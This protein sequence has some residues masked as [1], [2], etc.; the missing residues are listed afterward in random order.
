MGSSVEWGTGKKNG[1]KTS[2][3][4]VRS[5]MGVVDEGCR[6]YRHDR[7]ELWIF[8]PKHRWLAGDHVTW[9]EI[10][11][12]WLGIRPVLH[13]DFQV[14]PPAYLSFLIA[15]LFSFQSSPRHGKA[16]LSSSHSIPRHRSRHCNQGVC[17]CQPQPSCRS[18]CKVQTTFWKARRWFDFWRLFV[19]RC[20]PREWACGSG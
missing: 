3:W 12:G 6:D 20:S 15:S 14:S 9:S 13:H 10:S 1:K 8:R 16:P 5:V 17:Y 4:I 18:A 7:Y 11:N 19:R 2:P